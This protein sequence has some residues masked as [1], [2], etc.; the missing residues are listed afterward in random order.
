MTKADAGSLGPLADMRP[1]LVEQSDVDALWSHINSTIDCIATDHA[2]HTL[3]E[4]YSDSP[5]PGIS[6]LETSLPL[7]LT[8]VHHGKLSLTRL[9][10]LM[11]TNPRRIFNLP[12]QP[13]TYLEVETDAVYTIQ[14]QNLYTKCGWTP[15]DGR[16]VRGQVE[17]VIL[18]GRTVYQNGKITA[19]PGTG[20]VL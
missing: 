11:S 18:E 10:E 16:E 5:P 20:Q 12:E 15:F 8:A 9:I 1:R 7:M 17:Q 19:E 2:P 3:T 14:N 6:G 4:K 13:D